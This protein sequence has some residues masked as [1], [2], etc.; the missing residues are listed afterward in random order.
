MTGDSLTPNQAP[1]HGPSGAQ[2]AQ[3]PAS[4]AQDVR[5]AAGASERRTGLLGFTPVAPLGPTVADLMGRPLYDSVN[6]HLAD[7]QRAEQQL[8]FVRRVLEIFSLSHAD[9]YDDLLWRVDDGQIHLSA[10]VSD[11]FAWGAADAEEI[12]PERLPD[13]ERTY[14]D[15]KAID[16]QDYTAALYAA[17]IRHMRPQGAAYPGRKLND[18][19]REVVALF[20]ACGPRREVGLGNPKPQPNPDDSEPT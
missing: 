16:S 18:H 7:G 15:L 4:E 12:T 10:N 17:R 14:A 1:P 9:A 8:A 3:K 5:D 20:D 19:W 11:V 6:R 13:L 2:S